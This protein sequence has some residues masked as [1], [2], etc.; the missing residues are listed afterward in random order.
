MSK[1][2]VQSK[3][4]CTQRSTHRG[5]W[6][7]R[8]EP[9]KTKETGRS[10]KPRHSQDLETLPRLLMVSTICLARWLGGHQMWAESPEF[11]LNTDLLTLRILWLFNYTKLKLFQEGGSLQ[12]EMSASHTQQDGNAHAQGTS[13]RFLEFTHFKKRAGPSAPPRPHGFLL[14]CSEFFASVFFKTRSHSPS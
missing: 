11:S 10:L 12:K 4:K 13:T 3:W 14:T 7:H 6:Q 1:S 9:Q 2:K 5:V 8:T